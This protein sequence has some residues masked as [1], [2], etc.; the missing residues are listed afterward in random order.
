MTKRV[1]HQFDDR[2]QM[3]LGIAEAIVSLGA[4]AIAARARFVVALSGGNTP[5]D[6]YHALT[7][8]EYRR[9][10]DW[11]SVEYFWGDERTVPPN[12]QQ[13]N[14]RMAQ[15]NLLK[16]LGVRP[17]HIHRIEAERDEV[18]SAAVDY[19]MEIANC[20]GVALKDSPPRFDL[21]LLG[22]GEDGHTAS[23]FPHTQ[24]LHVADRWIVANHVPQLSS[25]RITMTFPL[26]NRAR[27][28]FFLVAG[29]S[30][31]P[32][33]AQAL[34]GPYDPASFPTQ[35]IRPTDGR[36]EWFVDRAAAGQLRDADG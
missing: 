30:K 13:S 23:L 8:A 14:Y 18:E 32:A 28:V 20:F 29:D 1:T 2:Q 10:L 27:A 12:H 22:L 5:R 34:E 17:A 16:P 25:T 33:L 31:A 21:I 6:L 35:R 11:N 15:D 9:R 3:S 7:S 19:A 36:V 4:E 24:A 26:I